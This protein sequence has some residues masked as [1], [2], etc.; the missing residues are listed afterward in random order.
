V[1]SD[2]LWNH[3]STAAELHAFVRATG[4]ADPMAIADALVDR[5]NAGG[6]Q[7]NITAVLARI[8]RDGT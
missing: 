3:L 4:S 1:C 6:G 8:G 2:G 7:D 5:A